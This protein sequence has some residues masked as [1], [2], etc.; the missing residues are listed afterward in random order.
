MVASNKYY[1]HPTNKDIM[2]CE[3]QHPKCIYTFTFD[4]EDY[5]NLSER[6]WIL[7]INNKTNVTGVICPA[8]INITLGMF[9]ANPVFNSGKSVI[10]LDGVCNNFCKD[11]LFVVPKGVKS[12]KMF[13][14]FK[15]TPSNPYHPNVSVVTMIRNGIAY[16]YARVGFNGL[17]KYCSV[18][19][20]LKNGIVQALE[21]V[22]NLAIQKHE[23]FL[24]LPEYKEIV[25]RANR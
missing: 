15:P 4:T 9:L 7:S 20:I 25:E 16:Q 3:I 2:I 18:S 24:N 6:N 1:P 13:T 19:S 14:R 10:H 17:L 22:N 12:L 23:E 21:N 8:L 11:N 5:T